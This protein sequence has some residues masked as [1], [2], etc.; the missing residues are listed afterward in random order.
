MSLWTHVT[1][2]RSVFPFVWRWFHLWNIRGLQKNYNW[3]LQHVCACVC[4]LTL[5]ICF[6]LCH[7]SH[8][9]HVLEIVFIVM[10]IMS[11]C[12]NGLQVNSVALIFFDEIWWEDWDWHFNSLVTKPKEDHVPCDRDITLFIYIEC[13]CV[14]TLIPCKALCVFVVYTTKKCV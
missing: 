6:A 4:L 1:E 11:H 14:S 7:Y 10:K 8:D 12:L 5:K 3:T 13:L 9:C 2:F